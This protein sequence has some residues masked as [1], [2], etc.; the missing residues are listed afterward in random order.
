MTR[1]SLVIALL[2]AAAPGPASAQEASPSSV[3][4]EL[5]GP[6]IVLDYDEPPKA[7][8]ITR[9]EYPKDAFEK[10]I[11]GTVVVRMLIDEKGRVATAG[12]V[13][14]IPA[15]DRAAIDC[16]K[17]WTFNPATKNGRAVVTF[18]NAPVTFRIFDGP[19]PFRP[20]AEQGDDRQVLVVA[21]EPAGADFSRWVGQLEDEVREHWKVP[22]GLRSAPIRSVTLEL[23]VDRNGTVSNV[24][25]VEPSAAVVAADILVQHI[26][27]TAEDALRAS[28]LPALPD[29]YG[30]ASLPLKLRFWL[31]R[32]RSSER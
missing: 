6:E 20:S 8:H 5:T 27:R 2:L 30:P 21:F 16:V 15:L 11:E 22:R 28:R 1:P 26:E 17:T 31:N 23:T 9:P 19:A 10:K 12:V 24:R 3:G 14:S 25:C 32:S 7:V 18:A 4:S 13:E 29:D